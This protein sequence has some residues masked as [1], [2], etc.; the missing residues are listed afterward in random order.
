[1]YPEMISHIQEC[2]HV[3]AELEKMDWF[4]SKTYVFV[5]IITAVGLL[6]LSRTD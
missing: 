2:R 4:Y 6:R 5:W 1:L 3:V